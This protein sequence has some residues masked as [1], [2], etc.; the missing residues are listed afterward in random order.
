MIRAAVRLAPHVGENELQ[1]REVM[2][3]E[4]ERRIDESAEHGTGD[5]VR[6]LVA[7]LARPDVQRE[8]VLLARLGRR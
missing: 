5:L 3:V 6:L 8:R 1:V 4:R 2:P 7:A